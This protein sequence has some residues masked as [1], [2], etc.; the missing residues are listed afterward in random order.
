MLTLTAQ[1]SYNLEEF[2]L[3]SVI[4]SATQ[5]VPISRHAAYYSA[6]EYIQMFKSTEAKGPSINAPV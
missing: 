5:R 3:L 6:F 1:A 2:M 4:T